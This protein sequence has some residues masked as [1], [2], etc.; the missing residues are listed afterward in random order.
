MSSPRTSRYAF[1]LLIVAA[2][3]LAYSIA[4]TSVIWVEPSTF[5]LASKLSLVYWFGLAFLGCLWYVGRHSK[6]FLAC[7]FA[8]T[9]LYL[10]VAPTVI[11]V[12]VWISNSYYPFGESKLIAETGH[13]DYRSGTTIISYL[14]WPA[15]L[16]FAS[17]FSLVTGIP[18]YLL[19]KC[20]PL[21]LVTLY[22]L[23]LI[24][25]QRSRVGSSMAIFGGALL[26]AG[27]FIRQQYFGPQAISYVLFLVDFLIVSWLFFDDKASKR[28]LAFLLLFLFAVTTF[29]HPLTSLMLLVTMA[30]LYITYRFLLKKS[31]KTVLVLCFVSAVVWIGYQAYF[32]S[33]FFVVMVQHLRDLLSGITRSNIVSESSR[34]IGSRAME[35]NF[36]TSYAIV[37]LFAGVALISILLISR[38]VWKQKMHPTGEQEYSIFNMVL[39]VMLALFAFTGIYGATEAYQRAFF[40]GLVPLTFLCISLLKS[41]PKLLV[42]FLVAVIFLNIPAQYGSDTY[43]LATSAQLDGVEFLVRSTPQSFSVIGKFTLYIRYYDPL[44][45]YT[46]PDIGLGYP[47]TSLPNSSVVDEAVDRVLG[48]VNYVMRSGLEDN[49]YIFFLG[50]NP[51]D[52]INLDA[53]CDRVYSNGQ[54]ILY[55]PSNS[56]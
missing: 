8:L 6:Y 26:L 49:F 46:V 55:T 32:A 38:K 40:F 18:D 42:L 50:S 48:Q 5:G 27:F 35:L 54:F 14:D 21:L 19:L 2:I 1:V 34:L 13:V 28:T 29:M 23:F 44:K 45:N 37:G 53:K 12:P 51:F 10:Y 25:I 15:F 20:F 3:L 43:R 24:L 31:S 4:S 17:Q 47:F 11:R 52:S 22:G 39:L 16:Y 41:K 56:T 36:V 33:G 9:I 30:S 7:S